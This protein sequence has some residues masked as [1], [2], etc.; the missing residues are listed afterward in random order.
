LGRRSLKRES[1]K[2]KN[3]SFS[4]LLLI[5]DYKELSLERDCSI[6]SR[7]RRL[8]NKPIELIEHVITKQSIQDGRLTESERVEREKELKELLS[9]DIDM[10]NYLTQ[11]K[12]DPCQE[13]L[14]E[15]N[16]QSFFKQKYNILMMYLEEDGVKAVK[17]DGSKTHLDRKVSL[18][19]NFHRR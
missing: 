3:F 4:C 12:F 15:K 14:K 18:T 8:T 19:S 11:S 1:W 17:E 5:I 16:I 9:S 13:I 10:A 7:I 6:L 2:A